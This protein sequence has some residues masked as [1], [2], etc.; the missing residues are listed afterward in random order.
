MASAALA[1][2]QKKIVS[3]QQSTRKAREK[4]G[5]VLENTLTAAETVGTAFAF[6]VW[7]GRVD[8]PEDFEIMGIPMP[9]F[10]GVG[11][12]ALALFGVG[13]GMEGHMRALGNGALS[14]HMNGIGRRMGSEMK[15][16]G[17]ISGTAP[18][19]SIPSNTATKVERGTGITQSDLEALVNT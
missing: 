8:K 2:A 15:A 5:E 16:R 11:L 7:E 13:R 3:L 6:G 10:A 12:Q 18:R 14:A 19:G 9:L 1:R 17:G 4:A